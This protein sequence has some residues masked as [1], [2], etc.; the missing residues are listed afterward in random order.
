MTDRLLIIG[1]TSAIAHAVAR[2]YAARKAQLYLVGRRGDVLATNAADLRVLGASDVVTALLD[3]DDIVRHEAVLTT[4]YAT[5]SGFDAVLVAHGVLPNQGAS[6]L[7][8]AE[9]LRSF[10]TNAR[11]TIALLTL[12]SNEL[13]RHGSGVL[14]VISSPAGER[15]RASNY[16]YGAAKAAVTVFASGLR[17]RL[18]ARGV[19]VVTIVPGFVD[20][21]MTAGVPKGGLWATTTRTAADIEHAMQDGRGVLYT[22]WFWRWIMAIVRALPEG[23]F[24]RTDL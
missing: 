10:D 17:H 22:P 7:S 18:Y 9:T 12:L 21:P 24:V 5:F 20:T 23:V 4:A 11:S 19:R 14:A 15:G 8:V 3:V 13:E 6:Q 2:R 16:V 1:A